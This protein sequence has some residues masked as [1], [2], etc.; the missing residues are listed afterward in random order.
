MKL[1][2]CFLWWSL[3]EGEFDSDDWD[4]DGSKIDGEIELLRL[5]GDDDDDD[6][7]AGGGGG[8]GGGGRSSSSRS[9]SS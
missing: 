1:L 4:S 9:N 3:I 8:G 7:A 5:D 2:A 6:G